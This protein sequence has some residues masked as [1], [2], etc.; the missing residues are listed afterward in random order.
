MKKKLDAPKI[1]ISEYPF[2]YRDYMFYM[3]TIKGR[4]VRTINAYH[5]DLFLF[6]RFLKIVKQ[7]LSLDDIAEIS[8][9]DID[10]DFLKSITLSDIYAF[11]NYVAADRDNHA[12]TRARKASSL[13]SYFNYMTSKA[14]ILTENPTKALESPSIKKSIPKYLTLE[15]SILLL[16]SPQL[17]ESPRDFCMVT[18]LLNCGMRLSELVGIDFDDIKGDHITILGKGNKER[19]LYLN[20]S[21]LESI[22]ACVID[23][24]IRRKNGEKALFLNRNGKRISPRRVEQILEEYLVLTGLSG[25]GISPHKLRHTAA[26]L[27]YRH[28]GADIRVLKEVLGHTN[29]S[30]TEIYTHVSDIQVDNAMRS[31]PIANAVKKK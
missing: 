25:R 16:N 13:R 14:N 21:C 31:N 29:I 3:L 24:N 6:F 17:N 1:S 9:S 4:S 30:T 20:D 2:I 10:Y 23:G 26:T 28:G 27:M 15:E 19:V 18:L 5:Q 7:D 12:N 8:I 11:L 22:N